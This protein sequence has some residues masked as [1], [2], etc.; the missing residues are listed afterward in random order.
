MPNAKRVFT[1]LLPLLLAVLA[2]AQSSATGSD[3]QPQPQQTA[4]QNR[5]SVAGDE[6]AFQQPP[7]PGSSLDATQPADAA[8][9]KSSGET[10]S[11][12]RQQRLEAILD[13]RYTRLRRGRDQEIAILLC[14][15]EHSCQFESVSLKDRP[16]PVS[17][18]MERM[19]G[20]TVSYG[21]PRHYKPAAQGGHRSRNDSG[22]PETM[23]IE[24]PIT[25]VDQSAFVTESDWPYIHHPGRVAG[26]VA[27][28]VGW[29]AL[30]IVALPVL[31]IVGLITCG[32]IDC[33]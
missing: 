33:H 13:Q 32:S 2:N 4:G 17:L 25:V 1:A 5:E 10:S 14:P 11:G 27:S 20:L 15:V 6:K 26:D 9:T 19:E 18:R 21:G 8:E 28:N 24:I 29:A 23:A 7:S 3:A 16:I 12:A 22:Q 30:F 31:P